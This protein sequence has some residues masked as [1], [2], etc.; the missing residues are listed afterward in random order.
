MAKTTDPVATLVTQ[1]VAEAVPKPAPDERAAVEG[2]LKPIEDELT[3]L[4]E[5]LKAAQDAVEAARSVEERVKHGIEVE[6]L[7]Q[8][9]ERAE[10]KAAPLRARLAEIEAAE[11]RARLEAE[12]KSVRGEMEAIQA[13]AEGL[14]SDLER[15]FATF[16][17]TWGELDA[18]YR[19]LEA[20][21]YGLEKELGLIM[22]GAI[23]FRNGLEPALFGLGAKLRIVHGGGT[24]KEIVTRYG[25]R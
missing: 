14:V 17:Q 19:G 11:H 25:K 2:A 13:K 15:G 6:A 10:A 23:E 16:A 4:R 21:Q 20:R 3:A 24:L 7:R 5:R 8:L 9:I 12:L 18:A 22:P 1:A